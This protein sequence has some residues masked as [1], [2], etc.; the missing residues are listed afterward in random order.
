MTA[1]RLLPSFSFSSLLFVDAPYCLFFFFHEATDFCSL[2]PTFPPLRVSGKRRRRREGKERKKE[3]RA[4]G[5][6]ILS[7][8]LFGGR[9]RGEKKKEEEAEMEEGGR[10]ASCSECACTR[11]QN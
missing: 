5:I 2:P 11:D 9:G 4:P 6:G 7:L 3:R 10:E 8:R 1:A